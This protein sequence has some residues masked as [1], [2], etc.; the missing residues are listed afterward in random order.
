MGWI[1]SITVLEMNLQNSLQ[2]TL[3]NTAGMVPD[4]GDNLLLRQHGGGV[5]PA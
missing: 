1:D 4:G 5:R 3:Q 2:K